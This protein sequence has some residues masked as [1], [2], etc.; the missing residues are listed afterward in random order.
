MTYKTLDGVELVN[1]MVVWWVGYAD[2]INK[3]TINLKTC[4]VE[5][6]CTYAR[7]NGNNNP[8]YANKILAVRAK[9]D[10]W[11]KRANKLLAEARQMEESGEDLPEKTSYYYEH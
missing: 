9:A 5:W 3:G 4:E 1:G 6:G 2:R 8:Y 11:R 7:I 10:L